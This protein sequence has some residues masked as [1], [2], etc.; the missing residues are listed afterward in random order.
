MPEHPR[1]ERG[2]RLWTALPSA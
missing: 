2:A 1:R